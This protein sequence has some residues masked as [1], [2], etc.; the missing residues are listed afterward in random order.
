MHVYRMQSSVREQWQMLYTC[1]VN[2]KC[3]CWAHE[4]KQERVRMICSYR[5]RMIYV[6]RA[7]HIHRRQLF[8]T[9]WT[10]AM[11]TRKTMQDSRTPC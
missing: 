7:S 8:A 2:V 5:L 3:A 9:S 10:R 1:H 11:F 4:F 6:Y